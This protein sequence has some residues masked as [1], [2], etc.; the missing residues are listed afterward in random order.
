M[1]VF[2]PLSY[3]Q[4]KPGFIRETTA[5]KLVASNGC[6]AHT[7]DQYYRPVIHEVRH[8]LNDYVVFLLVGLSTGAFVAA[9]FSGGLRVGACFV[10]A[11][12]GDYFSRLAND[13]AT[14]KWPSTGTTGTAFI[15]SNSTD[16]VTASDR[17][18]CPQL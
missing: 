4:K 17:Y 2:M 15:N 13:A 14:K 9:W 8:R 3:L 1:M 5:I 16:E 12:S 6:F 18:H 10:A 11:T 7:G